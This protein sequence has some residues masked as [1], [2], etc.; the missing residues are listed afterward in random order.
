MKRFAI[1]AVAVLLANSVEMPNTPLALLSAQDRV[2]E[3]L[4]QVK[5]ALG[6]YHDVLGLD[7]DPG[8]GASSSRPGPTWSSRATRSGRR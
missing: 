4:G 5:K 1:L 2:A 3:V 7:P 6:V 8:R